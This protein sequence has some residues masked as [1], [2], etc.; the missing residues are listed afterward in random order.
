MREVPGIYTT[1]VPLLYAVLKVYNDISGEFFWGIRRW[2]RG[3]FLQY[4][5]QIICQTKSH[6]MVSYG[7]WTTGTLCITSKLCKAPSRIV[8]EGYKTT[9]LQ[10][11]CEYRWCQYGRRGSDQC[12]FNSAIGDTWMWTKYSSL[13]NLVFSDTK[14]IPGERFHVLISDYWELLTC[15][16][17]D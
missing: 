10:C 16:R 3:N 7:D 12:L 15:F 2:F 14:E 8:S 9:K 17:V 6:I 4:S 1:V 13:Y 11:M 5:S